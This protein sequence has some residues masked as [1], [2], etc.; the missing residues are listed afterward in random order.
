MSETVTPVVG[1][2]QV[3]KLLKQTRATLAHALKQ[4]N[5]GPR[6]FNDIRE[7][8]LPLD[9]QLRLMGVDDLEVLPQMA[10]TYVRPTRHQRRKNMH[11]RKY[12]SYERRVAD[13]LKQKQGKA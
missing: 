13:K 12:N 8:L 1:R 6:R 4:P 5:I 7:Q 2:E 11:D 9:E 3:I 10:A